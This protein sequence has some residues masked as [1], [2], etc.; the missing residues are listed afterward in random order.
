VPGTARGKTDL[1]RAAGRSFDMPPVRAW[2]LA[3]VVALVLA[4]P[5]AAAAPNDI[6]VSGPRIGHPV[7][8]ANWDENLRLLLAVANAPRAR[9]AAAAGLAAR[10]RLDLAEFWAWSGRPK[11]TSAKLASQHGS[12]YPAQGARPAVI[13]LTVRGVAVPRLVPPAAGRIFARHGIP[14]RL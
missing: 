10:P 5:A 2:L 7:L 13:V 3:L 6:L 8:L 4:A 14:L 12:L 9:G 1:P 11:P